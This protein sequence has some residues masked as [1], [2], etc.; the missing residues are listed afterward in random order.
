MAM[1][2]PRKLIFTPYDTTVA[3]L[4][5]D[6]SDFFVTY[7][8][9]LAGSVPTRAL[10]LNNCWNRID[11][12]AWGQTRR[13]AAEDYVKSLQWTYVGQRGVLV[14]DTGGFARTFNNVQFSGVALEQVDNNMMVE[15]SITFTE[16]L[17]SASGLQIARS[18]QWGA[19]GDADKIVVSSLN[20]TVNYFRRD[21]TVFKEVFRSAPIRVENGP[22]ESILQINALEEPITG[23]TPLLR[24]QTA[25]ARF[26]QWAYTE[27]GRARALKLD[28]VSKGT[29]HLRSVTPGDLTLPDTVLYSLEFVGAYGS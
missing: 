26:T 27:I 18:L 15:F 8:T 16:W 13:V 17:G 4:T 3:A 5:L 2:G 1:T 14:V 25:E 11:S 20:L 22:S 21:R 12:G 6:K 29:L 23:S 24:R 7:E 19:D 10:T 28:G 9:S